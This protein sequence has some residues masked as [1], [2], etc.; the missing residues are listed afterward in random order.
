MIEP[1]VSKECRTELCEECTEY[2]RGCT[3]G[4]HRIGQD[5]AEPVDPP[6]PKLVQMIRYDL[7]LRP[8]LMIW[9]VLPIELTKA[10]ADRLCGIIQTLPLEDS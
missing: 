10:D 8:G 9:L 5:L 3:C 2:E 6:K 1:W 4:C 7:P